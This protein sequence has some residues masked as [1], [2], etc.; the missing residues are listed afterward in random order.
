MEQRHEQTLGLSIAM[1]ASSSSLKKTLSVQRHEES[2]SMGAAVSR[3]VIH[4][5]AQ[6]LQLQRM[7]LGSFILNELAFIIIFFFF[8][9]KSILV[10][11]NLVFLF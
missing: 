4:D 10:A 3:N 9:L 6:L 1:V 11:Y 8:T 5:I 2:M 7:E